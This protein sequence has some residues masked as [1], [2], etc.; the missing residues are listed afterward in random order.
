MK[1]AMVSVHAS[2]LGQAPGP[3]GAHVAGLS[4]ELRRQGHEVVV[5]CRWEDPDLPERVRTD[6]GYDVVHVSAGPPRSLADGDVLPHLGEFTSFLLRQW[7]AAPPHVVHGHGWMSGVVSVLG[8]RRIRVPVVQAFHSLPLGARRPG[9]GTGPAERARIEALVGKEAAHV[10]AASAGEAFALASAGVRRT[11]ISVVSSGVDTDLFIPENSPARREKPSLV[12]VAGPPS[13]E[14]VEG[15]L[16]TLSRV[17]DAELMITGCT[18]DDPRLTSVRARAEELGVASRVVFAAPVT[19][20]A[21][22]ALLHSADLVLC[23]PEDEPTGAVAL[24]AMACGIPVVATSTG[25]LA[26]IVVDEVTGLLVGQDDADGLARA[27]HRLLRDDTLREE[28]A[29]AGRDRVT[30]RYSWSQVASRVV[31]AYERAGA[32]RQSSGTPSVDPVR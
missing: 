28:F 24:E 12:L 6:D 4:A 5:Y 11:R 18:A 3:I 31:R 8:G 32:T 26:D 7:A 13:R 23:A 25:E 21:M 9:G 14:A 19:R 15:V 27:V 29:V 22:P 20:E 30:A 1:I 10:V 2:P 17:D 16:V